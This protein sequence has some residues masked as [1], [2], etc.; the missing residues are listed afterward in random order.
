MVEQSE[1]FE[2]T[3]TDMEQIIPKVSPSGVGEVIDRI[4]NL[5]RIS[6][7][8]QEVLQSIGTPVS[9]NEY[10]RI[11]ESGLR[12]QMMT[13]VLDSIL[14]LPDNQSWQSVIAQQDKTLSN[15]D[16]KVTEE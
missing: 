3:S 12:A 16:K 9:E 5:R 10:H 11:H 14:P 2:I 15:Q 8:P 6:E 7:T 4:I 13:S 1:G